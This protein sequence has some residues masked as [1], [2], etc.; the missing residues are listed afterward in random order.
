LLLPDWP[1]RLRYHAAML[2]LLLLRHAKS[3]WDDPSLDDFD[4]PLAERGE[5]AAPRMG[6]YMREQGLAPD[7]VLCS[8]AKRARQTLDLVLPH[9]AG[10]ADVVYDKGLYL[11]TPAALLARIRKI[12]PGVRQAMVVG[13]DPG[14][15]ML[16]LELA[17]AGEPERLQ[18][19]ARKF[20]TGAL[21]MIRFKVRNW[22]NVEPGR[23][24]L[25][26]FMSPKG[27]G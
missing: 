5:A 13:H 21:A 10:K 14:M 15:H 4:R 12:G 7:L 3:S 18:A 16:A 8:T 19:L 27:L 6:A 25:V 1:L 22:E 2:T 11:A 17:G 20:P 23:G 9:L 26:L 24:S